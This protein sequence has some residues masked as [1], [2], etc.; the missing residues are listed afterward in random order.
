[1]IQAKRALLSALGD[2]LRHVAPE[3]PATFIPVF[4]APKQAAHGDLAVTAAMQLAKPLKKNPR[5][6]AS[7]LVA[8]LQAQ[9]AVAQW[10]SAIEIAG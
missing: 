10:V 3:A 8:A 5:E 9:P 6:L 4:E 1:M 2:A 7:A